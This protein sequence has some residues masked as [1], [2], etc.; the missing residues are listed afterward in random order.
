MP[1][2]KS[3]GHAAWLKTRLRRMLAHVGWTVSRIKPEDRRNYFVSA[4]DSIALPRGAAEDL[5]ADHPKLRDLRER[6]AKLD[7]PVSIHSQW[8]AKKVSIELDLQ[9]FRGD[10]VYVWQYRQMRTG[11]A[12]LRQYLAMKYVES[13]DALGL[14]PKLK[15][16]GLFGCWLFQYGSRPAVSRDL[17]DSV[18]EINFLEQKIGLT[19]Q[20]GLR[21]LD[22]GAGYGRLAYRMAEALPNLAA[23]DCVDAV[24]ESTFLCS[25]Y[26]NYRGVNTKAR[27]IPLDRLGEELAR[28]YHLAVNIHSFSECRREAIRWWL[29]RVA[30]R[31]IPWL[32]VVPNDPEQLLSTE[33]NGEH[34][35][36]LPDVTAAG[37]ELACKAPVYDD[38]ELLDLISVRDHYFLFRR[39]G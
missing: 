39:R 10:N 36:F 32:L 20:P 34:L 3:P 22:I 31:D 4:D 26:L 33:S 12:R 15:E 25:Y 17:L 2:S 14:L 13:R 11:A 7:L 19:G 28:Q 37:Y 16:D 38:A 30:E 24:P 27:A 23:Y 6:Y 21:V 9:R 29:Q 1:V 18:N 8:H 35:D 5:R